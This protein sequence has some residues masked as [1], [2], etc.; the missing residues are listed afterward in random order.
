MRLAVRWIPV[1]LLAS[2]RRIIGAPDYDGYLRHVAECHS[3]LAPVSEREFLDE[4]LAARYSRAG[5]RCC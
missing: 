4:R 3:E 5:S 2:V 1:A